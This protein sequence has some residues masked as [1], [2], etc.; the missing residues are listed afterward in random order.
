MINCTPFKVISP[1]IDRLDLIFIPVINE[2]KAVVI[3]IPADGPS[4]GIEAAGKCMWI[5]ILSN[6]IS[7]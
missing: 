6:I 3:V 4:L 5:S 1:G 2:T 7:F